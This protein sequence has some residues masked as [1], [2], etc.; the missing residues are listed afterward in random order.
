MNNPNNTDNNSISNTN[1]NSNSNTIDR[2]KESP[3]PPHS[4]HALAEYALPLCVVGIV[5]GVVYTVTHYAVA[6][7]AKATKYVLLSV[8]T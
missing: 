4:F 6:P 7:L 1:N 8:C 5:L 2:D 3:P